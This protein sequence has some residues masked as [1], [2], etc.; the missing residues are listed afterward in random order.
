MGNYYN[1]LT[2]YTG[3]PKKLESCPIIYFYSTSSLDY[4]LS[5]SVL[6]KLKASLSKE[7]NLVS[8]VKNDSGIYEK[9]LSGLDKFSFDL[10]IYCSSAL[11]FSISENPIIGYTIF[12]KPQ[13]IYTS[14]GNSFTTLLIS[15]TINHTGKETRSEAVI[16]ILNTFKVNQLTVDLSGNSGYNFPYSSSDFQKPQSSYIRYTNR[17]SD[18]K[19]DSTLV[20]V[21]DCG[22]SYNGGNDYS[23]FYIR[24]GIQIE[25]GLY[26]NFYLGIYIDDLVLCRFNISTGN[27]SVISLTKTNVF[28]KPFE[29]FSGSLD[30][31]QYSNCEILGYSY[32]YLVFW[33]ESDQKYIVYFLDDNK[34]LEYSRTNEDGEENYLVTDFLDPQGNYRYISASDLFTEIKNT[35]IVPVDGSSIDLDKT[36]YTFKRKLG[37]WWEL[38]RSNGVYYYL[39]PYGC[40]SSTYT[41]DLIN[42]R[43]FKTQTGIIFPI[44]FGHTYT[45]NPTPETINNTYP[46]DLGTDKGIKIDPT[47]QW[48]EL[49]KT[50]LCLLDGLRRRP[51]RSKYCFPENSQQLG[52]IFGLIFYTENGSLYCY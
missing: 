32:S 27:Y 8:C 12:S 30:I 16:E 29:Y 48:G 23:K 6:D 33:K 52:S 31:T 50:Q 45:Y 34:F 18:M 5:L 2:Y 47:K 44:E 20:S 25:T 3:T 35:C 15:L 42:D 11:D 26:T 40:I 49:D 28:K 4:D 9:N 14:A 13:R 41:L 7:T 10:I 51:R 1:Y 17:L 21:T 37:S 24:Q 38:I 39:S 36:K 19:N 22:I 43:L 46:Q